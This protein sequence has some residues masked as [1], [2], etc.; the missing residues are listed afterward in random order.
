MKTPDTDLYDT[1]DPAP[2]IGRARSRRDLLRIGV[3]ATGSLLA[4]PMINLRRHRL[5]ACT[6]PV[7]AAQRGA[8]LRR[9]GRRQ[10]V[11]YSQR[12]I[13]LVTG[14]LVIDMLAPLTINNETQTRWGAAADGFSDEDHQEF[15]GSEIDVFHIAVGVGG[16]NL[17][18]AKDNTLQFVSTYNGIIANRPDVFLRI[19]A[20]GDFDRVRELGK[21]GVLIG[22]QNSDHFERPDDVDLFHGLGQRVSQLTYNARNRIGNGATERV[23]GG[24]S[25][26]GVSIVERMNRVGMAVDVSHSGDRTTLDAC[27]VSGRP[28]LFTHSNSRVLSGGHPRTKTDEAI[29]AMAATGG[30]MGIT[31]VRMFVKDSEP[32]TVEHFLDHID[33]VRDLIGI[34]HVGIGSDVDL[35]G[36]DDLPALQNAALRANYKGSY[37]F[38]DKIDI[39]GIDHP[40]RMFDVAEGLI[41]RG[42]TDDHIRAV[43]GGNFR[44]VLT[45]IWST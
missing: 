17:H 34:E 44:R 29:R 11:E 26:F 25:D 42:Y 5:E 40:K 18:E 43:L 28:V 36:Y 15:L 24:I 33:H 1:H 4:A 19:D 9:T 41:R 22:V 39:E 3:F 10:E 8:D 32:T 38:R 12:C 31:G 20:A 30:A 37:A 6:G 16:R 2:D 21:V 14:S 13:D 27:E 45:E 35:H 7:R 23:D